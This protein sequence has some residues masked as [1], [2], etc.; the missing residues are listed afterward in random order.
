[1]PPPLVVKTSTPSSGMHVSTETSLTSLPVNSRIS[2]GEVRR[3]RKTCPHHGSLLVRSSSSS[4]TALGDSGDGSCIRQASM[5]TWG[6]AGSPTLSPKRASPQHSCGSMRSGQPSRSSMASS[7]TSSRSPS[8]SR[9]V[10]FI[11]VSTW[12]DGNCR[13]M[14]CPRSSPAAVAKVC[15]WAPK[16]LMKSWTPAWKRWTLH[17]AERCASAIRRQAGGD[18]RLQQRRAPC[19]LGV[20]DKT[21]EIGVSRKDWMQEVW[22]SNGWDG[23]DRV[24]R[25]KF[26]YKREC[27]REMGVEEA[28][29]FLDQLPSLWAYSTKQWLRH[30][31]PNADPKPCPLAPLFDLATD[32]AG[33][34]LLRKPRRL[35]FHGS[36][37]R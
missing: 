14:T 34:L 2:S 33:E 37:R 17:L 11:S 7:P 26:R 30:T 16:Q 22:T 13:S 6:W 10:R 21:A 23:E 9:S 4:H 25:V 31:I 12:R 15:G 36:A 24:T 29:A 19:L 18:P 5:S 27:L 28:Y 8:R 1:M 20:Y 32:P 35:C 3:R